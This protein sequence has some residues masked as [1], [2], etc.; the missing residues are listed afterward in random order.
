MLSCICYACTP[1]TAVARGIIFLDCQSS[2]PPSLSHERGISG[3]PWGNFSLSSSIFGTNVHFVKFSSSELE[4]CQTDWTHSDFYLEWSHL[5]WGFF[6]GRDWFIIMCQCKS[7][8][9]INFCL[10]Y[11]CEINGPQSFVFSALKYSNHCA[12]F[13]V[14]LTL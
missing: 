6:L 10:N 7:C 8:C 3:T 2:I 9:C 12:F 5:E 1:A 14:C 4:E 13:V 11:C